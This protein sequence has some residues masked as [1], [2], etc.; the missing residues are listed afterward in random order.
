MAVTV[1]KSTSHYPKIGDA[2]AVIVLSSNC[3]VGLCVFLEAHVGLKVGS[4]VCIRIMIMP[5][6]P[7]AGCIPNK[8]LQ[9]QDSP[10]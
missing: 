2:R 8:G 10:R 7:M 4:L 3:S 1:S 9:L 6:M 5:W